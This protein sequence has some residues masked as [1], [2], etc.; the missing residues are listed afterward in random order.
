MTNQITMTEKWLAS[1]KLPHTGVQYWYDSNVP[2]LHLRLSALGGRTWNVYS[3][4]P[5][6]GRPVKISLGSYPDISLDGARTRAL[7]VLH[8][9]RTGKQQTQAPTLE[10]LV[11]IYSKAFPSKSNYSEYLGIL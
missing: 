3:H 2:K 5:L 7:E 11:K 6:L 9:I 1:K 10:E 8:E 4:S